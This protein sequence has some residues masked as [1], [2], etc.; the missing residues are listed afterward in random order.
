M[1]ASLMLSRCLHKCKHFWCH[2]ICWKVLSPYM[3]KLGWMKATSSFWNPQS[4]EWFLTLCS[5]TFG[6]QPLTSDATSIPPL[7]LP[8][9][10]MPTT[11]NQST[12]DALAASYPYTDEL[13]A[14]G[15]DT[16]QL[17]PAQ[18][19]LLSL[20]GTPGFDQTPPED[21]STPATFMQ[22]LQADRRKR[23]KEYQMKCLQGE[24]ATGSIEPTLINSPSVVCC[25]GQVAL[26]WIEC[27]L[28]WGNP[29]G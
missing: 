24:S 21:D 28:R 26:L 29:L 6:L 5:N 23:Q 8:S 16:P 20:I 9:V 7:T 18:S 14:L 10:S 25:R 1:N 15:L 13:A 27:R 12:I 19:A 2:C 17:T 3:S 4:E 22:K 11:P